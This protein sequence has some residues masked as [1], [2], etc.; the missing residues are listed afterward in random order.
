MS[1]DI[2]KKEEESVFN[3]LQKNRISNIYR[4]NNKKSLY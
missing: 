3:Y 2:A 1:I 4:Y